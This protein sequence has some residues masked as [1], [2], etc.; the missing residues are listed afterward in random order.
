M[1]KNK[2]MPRGYNQT[3][4]LSDRGFTLI[5]LL[6]VIAIIA[7]LAAILFPVFAKAREKARQTTCL[8][9]EKQLGLGFLQYISDYDETY[10][11][12]QSGWAGHEIYPYIKS[13][14]VFT[15]PSDPLA[16]SPAGMPAYSYN[17]DGLPGATRC[18]ANCVE[19]SYGFN[20]F[21]NIVGVGIP[22]SQLDN[23]AK[24]ICLFELSGAYTDPSDPHEGGSLEEQNGGAGAPRGGNGSNPKQVYA[25][26]YSGQLPIAQYFYP[27]ED[28]TQAL[29]P[30][31]HSD[32]SNYLAVDGHVKWLM[33]MS[34]STGKVAAA[35]DCDQNGGSA[36]GNAACGVFNPNPGSFAWK[37]AG[38]LG[39]NGKQPVTMT[40]SYK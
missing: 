35:P 8:S 7:L 21:T 11:Y 34:I 3:M 27:N 18:N 10:P 17:S 19:T 38:T 25:M 22:M 9:N 26:G 29:L 15:C 33:P 32:G 12:C 40:F 16:G 36:T 4:R 28:T 1:L 30:G 31:R 20:A 14:D 39:R 37:A 2:L 6:V 24:I 23:S 5:E 13:K